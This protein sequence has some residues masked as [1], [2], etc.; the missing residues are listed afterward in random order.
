MGAHEV[1]ACCRADLE[2]IKAQVDK[3]AIERLQQVAHTPFERITY[4]RAIELLEEAVRA[5]KK[6]FEYK[7]RLWL[8]GSP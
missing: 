4:T 1:V 2:F 7:V 8:A 3:T 6:K 5:K